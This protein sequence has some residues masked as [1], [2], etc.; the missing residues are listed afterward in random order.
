MKILHT[1]DW[2]IGQRLYYKDRQK[3]HSLF[4]EWL[5]SLINK[6]KVE[7]LIVSGDIFDVAYPSNS[8]LEFYYKTLVDLSKTC[9]ENII[10]TGGNHDSI[11]TL[12]APRHILKF[13]NVFV[14]GGVDQSFNNEIIEIKKNDEIQFAVAAVPYLRDKDIRKSKA[15][16]TAKMRSESI[17]EG[18]KKHY[19]DL[20]DKMLIYKEKN[21]PIIAT[22]HFFVKGA[23][24]SDSERSIYVGNLEGFTSD[25]FPQEFDYIALGHIHRPQ[26]VNEK[27][28]YSGS[29]IPLSFSE[30]KDIKSVII[31]DTETKE[32]NKIEIP[33][34]KK[35]ISIKGNFEEVK[36]K[37]K[38]YKSDSILSKRGEKDWTDVH[39]E[40]ENIIPALGEIFQ[41]FTED[42]S[43]DIEIINHKIS[44]KESIKGTS[45]LFDTSNSLKDLKPN[46]IF[47]K[48]L[49]ENSIIEKDELLETFKE[50]ISEIENEPL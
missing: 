25:I 22:G 20:A 18:I 2:H 23:K 31:F 14:V 5:I 32:Q 3:E 19:R 28:R 40:E 34:F 33:V 8:A 29:P 6:E 1:S 50:L 26:K 12:N 17:R 35:L 38:Q 41:K 7:V 49:D 39:I 21:I 43:F 37:L 16:E 42:E 13:L 36:Q 24:I 10:I 15:G 46:E 9:C 47:E 30:R 44:F 45:K 11:S 48:L 27:I 4:F